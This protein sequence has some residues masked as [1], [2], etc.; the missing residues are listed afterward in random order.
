MSAFKPA[1]PEVTSTKRKQARIDGAGQLN[2]IR[3]FLSIEAWMAL[4]ALAQLALLALP[5]KPYYA[6][7]PV[8]A[9]L[10]LSILNNSLMLLGV[11]ENAYSADVL[12]G[13]TTALVPDEDGRF[14]KAGA[15]GSKIS[16]FQL[17][18]KSH[19]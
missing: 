14:T 3:D 4:G 18:V 5:I 9:Y 12:Y 19:Q 7:A 16:V 8:L 2:I 15:K 13:R 17:G 6:A 10:V 1:Q 11:K